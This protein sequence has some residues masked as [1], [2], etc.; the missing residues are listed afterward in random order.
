MKKGTGNI[1]KRRARAASANSAEHFL[2]KQSDRNREVE[3]VFGSSTGAKLKD[4][5]SSVGRLP[6][7]LSQVL[8]THFGLTAACI[9]LQ[10]PVAHDSF[11]AHVEED[12]LNEQEKD[13]ALKDFAR[14]KQAGRRL[15]E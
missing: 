5:M 2:N 4:R 7:C 13:D 8:T 12:E 9:L 10:M 15:C 3:R 1:R 6:F 14:Q 11:M